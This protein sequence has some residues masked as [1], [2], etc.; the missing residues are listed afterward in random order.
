MNPIRLMKSIKTG[1]AIAMLAVLAACDPPPSHD[2]AVVPE[3]TTI[4]DKTVVSEETVSVSTLAGGGERL[5]GSQERAA[6]FSDPVR[7]IVADATGN[8]YMTEGNRVRKITP[9]GETT[10]IAGGRD[11]FADGNSARFSHPYGITIDTAGNLYVADSANC[12]IRKIMP[13]GEV[14]TLVGGDAD[15]STAQT[16]GLHGITI[17]AA[18][19]LYATGSNRILKVTP[20]GE[21]STLAGNGE[22]GFA[23][24]QGSAAM[25]SSPAGIAIDATGNLYVTDL[26][27][28]RIRKI[29]PNGKV[30][31]LAGGEEGFANGKGSNARFNEP[32]SIAIDT[33]GNLYVT[34]RHEIIRKITPN[35]VVSTFA[36]DV[37]GFADGQGSAAR[38]N[39]P[40]NITIDVAGNLYVVDTDHGVNR[41][42]G[43]RIRKITPKGKVST[44][45]GS[46][47]GFADGSHARF[48][49][50]EG[51]VA[52]GS[53][54]L[55]VADSYNH[56]I[57]K[58][59][60]NGEVSTLAGSE[61]GFADGQGSNAQFFHPTDI[62]IDA[63]DNL[64]VADYGNLSVRKVTPNGEVSTLSGEGDMIPWQCSPT[65]IA[66]DMAGNL[67]VTGQREADQHICKVTPNGKV[68]ILAGS[69]KGFADGQAS[70]ARFHDPAGIA[71]DAAGNLYVA[72]W[73]NHRIRKVTPN[74]EVSTLAGGEE[75]FADGSNARFS[76]PYGITIDA[77]GNLYVAEWGNHRIR[78]VTPNGKVSTLAGDEEGFAEGN[79]ARFHS[80][81]GIA[82]DSTG[83]LYVAD[84]RN[85]RIRKI[86]I[87]RH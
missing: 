39:S 5:A 4:P 48:Y 57:R 15:R 21:V 42:P 28:H 60:P 61:K 22:Y 23:D 70:D 13:N 72:D 41:V 2:K 43:N 12:R 45:T 77:A 76:H 79:T 25:F 55:Y 83:N 44:L 16:C 87:R 75:G 63:A 10:T 49:H 68:S 1:T 18:N 33:T 47:G 82:I 71:I 31:T 32:G 84:A 35:G 6:L 62:A 67:Y 80:P 3:E 24:G 27:N 51:I 64:Y 40:R 7:G 8:L 17:D 30:S 58:V 19:N 20:N 11:G 46:E 52:D 34:D 81:H 86:E 73:G 74:G 36:G 65:G 29:T 69:E 56:R 9:N 53:G 26:N 38:F 37:S 14:S 85:H 78:K 50:P 66:I 59:T 54:N